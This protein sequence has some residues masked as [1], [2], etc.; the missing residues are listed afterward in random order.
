MSNEGSGWDIPAWVGLGLA[1]M[2]SAATLFM[3]G[4][5]LG[6]Y[7]ADVAGEL[8]SINTKLAEKYRID[9]E[10]REHVSEHLDT[11]AGQVSGLINR[12]AHAQGVE[13]G[14]AQAG[15]SE[16]RKISRT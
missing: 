16:R 15:L 7:K 2:S 12:E 1:L 10:F 14:R 13:E 3:T 8:K 11:L 6:K 5:G 4:I 9:Q